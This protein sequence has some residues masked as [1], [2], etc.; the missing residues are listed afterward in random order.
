MTL[1]TQYYFY[2]YPWTENQHI[3]GLTHTYFLSGLISSSWFKSPGQVGP[4]S[5]LPPFKQ[6]HVKLTGGSTFAV[7]VTQI[8]CLK[9]ESIHA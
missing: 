3:M 4:F 9:Q 8:K 1:V 5:G 7:C 2:V 6:M